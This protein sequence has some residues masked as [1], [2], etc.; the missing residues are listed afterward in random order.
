MPT[1]YAIVLALLGFGLAASPV[2]AITY[3]FNDV[4]VP[5][6]FSTS[7]LGI[8][9]PGQ[10][11]GWFTNSV[12]GFHGFLLSNGSYTTLDYPGAPN[13]LASDINDSG[14]IVGYYDDGI[15]IHGFTLINGQYTAFDYP[16]AANTYA[17]G[18]NKTGQ[19]VGYYFDQNN[20]I[21]GYKFSGGVFTAINVPHATQTQPFGINSTGHISGI[22]NDATG[23]HG[24]LIRNGTVQTLDVPEAV[25]ATGAAGLNDKDLVVGTY[26][27]PSIQK[28][29]G[30]LTNEVKYLTIKDPNGTT[31]FPSGINNKNVIV[32]TYFDS[33]GNEMSFTATPQLPMKDRG[34]RNTTGHVS[35]ASA[36]HPGRTGVIF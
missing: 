27:D 10:V 24:F 28:V 7:A 32:G 26:T 14:E 30:F 31:T 33:F 1:L 29:E 3:T 9:T 5:G 36:R 19:I 2:S 17:F 35:P 16:G 18:V 13:T 23:E 12:G 34:A 11:V 6:S 21:H 22:F 8:N 15:T 4:K 25:G 20:K